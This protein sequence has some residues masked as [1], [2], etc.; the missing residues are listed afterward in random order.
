MLIESADRLAELLGDPEWWVRFRAAESLI[1]FGEPGLALLRTAAAGDQ[2][3]ARD[4]AT[5]MLAE[6]GLPA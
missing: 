5:T 6:R 2:G 4:A 1:L 3:L